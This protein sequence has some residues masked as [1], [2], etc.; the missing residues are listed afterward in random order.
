[1]P[2][3]APAGT[4]KLTPRNTSPS[5]PDDGDANS[6]SCCEEEAV[7]PVG[8]VE[9]EMGVDVDIVDIVVEADVDVE[10]PYFALRLRNST[11]PFEGQR[12][13]T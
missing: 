13:S 9:E 1:M 6:S 5:C 11:L 12:S 8:E 10:V 2:I 3:F 4:V 7:E